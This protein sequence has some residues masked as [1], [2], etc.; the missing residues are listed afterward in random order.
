MTSISVKAPEGD[1][2]GS[3]VHAASVYNETLNLDSSSLLMPTTTSH[4]TGCLP[5]ASTVVLATQ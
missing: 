3:E 1:R 5:V 4:H 2:L